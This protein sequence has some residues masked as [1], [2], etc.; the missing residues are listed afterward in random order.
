MKRSGKRALGILLAVMLIVVMGAEAMAGVKNPWFKSNMMATGSEGDPWI[1]EQV[2][3]S[4]DDVE[5]SAVSILVEDGTGNIALW[6][7]LKN[8]TDDK[9]QVIGKSMFIND[10]YVDSSIYIGANAG[11][12]DYHVSL[13]KGEE[14]EKK[15]IDKIEKMD[16]DLKGIDGKYKTV[17]ETELLHLDVGTV[18]GETKNTSES[19]TGKSKD[20]KTAGSSKD[21]DDHSEV[22]GEDKFWFYGYYFGEK[23]YPEDENKE[24]LK[25]YVTLKDDGNGYLYWGDDNKGDIEYW[26]GSGDDF[27]MQAGISDFTDGCSLKDGILK[28]DIDGIVIVFIT[29]DV[30][31]TKLK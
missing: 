18:S 5:I 10:S 22:K 31:K 4:K 29:D 30:D 3:Y 17:F 6:L 12:T 15:K 1:E 7:K 27:S 8:G 21:Q 23:Y 11:E 13:V 19:K 25:W 2:I 24:M 14:L 20:S 9:L 26:K 16:F 28:L